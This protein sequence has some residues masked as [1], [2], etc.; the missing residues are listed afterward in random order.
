MQCSIEFEAWEPP[1]IFQFNLQNL[2]NFFS[3]SLKVFSVAVG[4]EVLPVVCCKV[5]D[6]KSS[7]CV[8]VMKGHVSAV[9]SVGFSADHRFMI[10]LRNNTSPSVD[11]CFMIKL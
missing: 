1:H 2:S 8:S 10:R 9:T 6:L 4:E 7:R 11:H 5:W 3:G